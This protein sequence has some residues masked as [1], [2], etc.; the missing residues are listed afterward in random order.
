MFLMSIVLENHH[1]YILQI[2][3]ISSNSL[4]LKIRVVFN[5]IINKRLDGI[6]VR[7]I[8]ET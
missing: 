8:E 2:N 5:N 4:V 6:V 3:S 1:F 7:A